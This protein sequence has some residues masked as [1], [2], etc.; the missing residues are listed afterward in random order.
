MLVRA[1]AKDRNDNF[2]FI[3]RKKE[4][5][6]FSNIAVG[7][8]LL[9]RV[10][11]EV[12]MKKVHA[13]FLLTLPKRLGFMNNKEFSFDVIKHIK[14]VE[15]LKRPSYFKNTNLVDIKYFIP[16]KT[17]FGSKI[18][19]VDWKDCLYVWYPVGG[20][21]KLVCMKRYCNAEEFFE[22]VGFLWGDG[23]TKNVRSLRF[24]NSE[25]STLI[26]VVN[27]FNKIGIVR[28]IW[29]AQIIWSGPNKP[30][31]SIEN[32][33]KNFW[34]EN[35]N[36]PRKNIVSVLWSEAK[37]SDFPFGSARLFI[38]NATLFEIFVNCALNWVKNNID[39]L[40]QNVTSCLLRGIAAAE[41]GPQL[42][43][44]FSLRRV[45]FSFNPES[46]ESE[47]YTRLLNKIN[48]AT[49]KPDLNRN[50][51]NV[52]GWNN[53]SKLYSIDVFKLHENKHKLF[54]KGFSNHRYTKFNQKEVISQQ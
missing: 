36:L 7:D 45:E 44:N 35:L 19:V 34:K 4:R 16:R 32:N 18:Y 2:Q 40:N 25:P 42:R 52:D 48:I 22:I 46:N 10:N 11:H 3:I 49:S 27:F 8:V 47:L 17:A 1:I 9:F 12:F 20:G 29:K 54:M 26:E 24:T 6:K 38:D 50:K 37:N 51:F 28:N 23:S 33:C 31:R 30:S 15:A 39:N 41:A 13:D 43:N 5:E 14:P 21:V 53:F